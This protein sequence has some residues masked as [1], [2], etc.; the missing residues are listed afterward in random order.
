[1]LPCIMKSELHLTTYLQ[2]ELVLSAILH[3][4]HMCL[5]EVVETLVIDATFATTHRD[6]TSHT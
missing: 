4:V 2:H 1:M 6:T 5:V 3:L